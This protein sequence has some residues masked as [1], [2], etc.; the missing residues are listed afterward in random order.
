MKNLQKLKNSNFFKEVTLGKKKIRGRMCIPSGVRCASAKAVERYFSIDAVGIVTTKSISFTPKAGYK[1]PLY[2]KY[3]ENSYTN[4]VGLANPGA[5][6]F[7]KELSQITVPQDKFLLVSIFG[8]DVESFY[9]AAAALAPYADGFELNMSCPHASGY[10][11]QL[12]SDINLVEQI[13]KK[14]SSEFDIPVFVKI[15]GSIPQVAKT[16][17][18]AMANGAYGITV[19]N[20]IG[21]GLFLLDGS[22][23]L[24]NAAGGLSGEAIRPLGIKALNDICQSIGYS[25]PI[26]GMGGIF[27]ARDIED[28]YTVGADF[29]G[30]GSSLTGLTTQQADQYLNALEYDLINGTTTAVLPPVT[31]MDY[32]RCTIEA[33]DEITDGLNR[34]KLS[35]W[36]NWEQDKENSTAA[37]FYFLTIP[38][39]GEK[40]FALYNAEQREFV[41]KN[42][43]YF[44]NILTS[45]KVGETVYLRG[46]YG[47]ALPDY[48]DCEINLVAGGSG[49]APSYEIARQYAKTNTVRFFFGGRT[50]YDIFDKHLFEKLGELNFA[51]EDGSSGTKGY[52]T[53]TLKNY[54]FNSAKTQ[55]FINIGPKPMLE[56]TYGI[57]KEITADKNIVVAIEYHTSC[58]VGICGK[59]ANE[60]GF[61]TCVDGPFMTVDDALKVKECG[62]L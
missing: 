3:S 27:T 47:K 53:E 23:L 57:E 7:A 10:G 48:S 51:T 2:A 25:N 6:V 58:G 38:Q 59:C 9:K 40:P 21:P 61:I 26:I 17:A 33:N 44:T 1:E 8:G 42:V 16:A 36:Q 20:T 12:G 13:T 55:I 30:I 43:G 45:L 50:Q 4:A 39:K 54:S 24:A 49:I 41:I 5:E 56:K 37:K 19:T 31:N 62:C 28:Y 29:F 32:Q 15:S 18:A 35:P 34:I 60:N 11:L 14:I 46:P 22:P 52:V